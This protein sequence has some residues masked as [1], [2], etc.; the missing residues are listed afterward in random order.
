MQLLGPPI[1]VI[2]SYRGES[3]ARFLS[4]ISDIQT[5]TAQNGGFPS[6]V[7]HSAAQ[8]AISAP[9]LM[10]QKKQSFFFPL[11]SDSRAVLAVKVL[12]AD[13]REIGSANKKDR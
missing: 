12:V 5:L 10:L 6:K 3:S 13:C 1:P 9:H 8:T 11:K 7:I 4:S 2:H